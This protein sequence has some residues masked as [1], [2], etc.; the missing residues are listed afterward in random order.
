MIDVT[1]L[2]CGTA[3]AGDSLRYG[4]PPARDDAEAS[5]R[6]TRARSGAERRP[7]VVWNCTRRCNLKCLHCYTASDAGA[8]PDELDTAEARAMLDDLAEFGVPAVLFSGGEPLVREDLL[9]LV[10]Y[11]RDLGHRPTLST[12]GTLITAEV[13]RQIKASGVTY[14]GISLDGLGEVN[15]HFRGVGGAFDKAV[16]AFRRLKDV[17]QRMGLRLTLTRSTARDL[18]GIFDFIEAEE[19]DRACFYHLVYAGRGGALTGDDLTY[20]ETRTAMEIIFRRTEDFHRRGIHKDI[21]TVDNHA[22]GVTLYLH[23]LARG[24]DRAEDVRRLLEWN[25]GAR[26]STGVGIGCIDFVGDVHPN[27]FWSHHTLG[28]VRRRPFSRIWLDTNDPLLAELRDRLP[29]LKGRCRVCRWQGFCG[30]SSRVRAEAVFGDCWAPEPACYL[31]DEEIG[32][33]PE[34]HRDLVDR[35]EDYTMPSAL[36]GGA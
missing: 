1:R 31:T 13:A 6:P 25:G 12:N 2:L 26:N 15:D 34:L 32:L 27:Q 23:L 20:A 35:G 18:D 10:R 33:T 24:D 4:T 28:N 21:L 16:A 7:V 30:G 14:V 8:A 29:L 36:A 9:D 22:D 17:D 3:T 11:A 5:A 19:I